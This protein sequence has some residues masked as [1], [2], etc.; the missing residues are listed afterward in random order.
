MS[1]YTIA[2]LHLCTH[3]P[4]NKSMEVFG[5][6]W[7]DY[8]TRLENNWRRL[9]TDEDTVVVP[10][11]ITW[12]LSLEEAV[13]DLKFIDS[14]PGKKILGKGNHDFWWSTMKKHEAIFLREGIKS[15]SFLFNNAHV[16]EDYIVAG[17]RGW[18][19]DD[20]C[21]NMP[22]SADFEKLTRREAMRLKTSL[23]EAV[24]LRSDTGREIIAFMHFPPCWSGVEAE[25]IMDLLEEYGVRRAYFGHIH[26]A[27]AESTIL[28]RGIELHLISA[29]HLGFVPKIVK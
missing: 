19:H 12:A 15:I 24:R 16:V 6:R 17:T 14:L 5:P 23:D 29:D 2:D 8:V 25:S 1:L 27:V 26:G 3:D 4:T 22:E 13:R 9:V 7:Q 28:S 21:R 20:E 11:D 10:G 18:F